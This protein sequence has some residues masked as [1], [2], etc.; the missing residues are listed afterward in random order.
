MLG[1]RC[2]RAGTGIEHSLTSATRTQW[3]RTPWRAV[4]RGVGA[5]H[6]SLLLALVA[7][8]RGMRAAVKP[9][10]ASRFTLA[11]RRQVLRGKRDSQA[12]DIHSIFRYSTE[13]PTPTVR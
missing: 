13:T 8:R 12:L 4:Q 9:A 3:E 10:S 7:V 1:L 5:S 6:I 2:H 11:T